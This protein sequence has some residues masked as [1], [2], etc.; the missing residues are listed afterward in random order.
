MPS[1]VLNQIK[2]IC[3]ECKK[4]FYDSIFHIRKGQGKYCSQKCWQSWYNRETKKIKK[5]QKQICCYCNKVFYHSG[6]LNGKT[7]QNFCSRKCYNNISKINV[8]CKNCGKEYVITYSDYKNKKHKF[9][10]RQCSGIWTAKNLVKFRDTSIE[11]LMEQ[12]LIKNKI[13]YQ[14]QV[15]ILTTAIVDFLLPN[16]I[17]L[18]CDGNFWHSRKINKG[19]DIA[20]DVVLNFNGYKV[21]RFT[22]TQI[23]KSAKKCLEKVRFTDDVK[24]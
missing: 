19:K 13:P 9:C 14:K 7:K 20:Q 18:Q 23:K 11:I 8:K 24:K 5:K 2:K 22:E 12:E 15:P 3:P 1:K 4:I 17:I 6:G 21:Y 16:K 10:S